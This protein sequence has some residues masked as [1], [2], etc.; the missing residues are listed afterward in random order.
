[1][2]AAL[3][4][5]CIIIGAMIQGFMIIIELPFMFQGEI[6]KNF[7]LICWVNLLWNTVLP[8]GCIFVYGF[9]RNRHLIQ[10]G[11]FY[12]PIFIVMVILRPVLKTWIYGICSDAP[13]LKILALTFFS[14]L[15][16]SLPLFFIVK[17]LF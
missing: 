4:L 7:K 9:L 17:W 15:I 1:M 2:I 3:V 10:Y 12:L 6:T 16:S 5:A 11:N 13:K 8:I 14:N